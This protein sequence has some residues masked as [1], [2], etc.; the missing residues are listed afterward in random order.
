MYNISKCYNM[1][2]ANNYKNFHYFFHYKMKK[3]KKRKI[4]YY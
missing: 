1:Y 2:S 3:N 4:T